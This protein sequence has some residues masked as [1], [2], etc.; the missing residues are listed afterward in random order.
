MIL[1]T[2][3]QFLNVFSSQL[4]PVFSSSLIYSLEISPVIFP[5]SPPLLSDVRPDRA[6][7]LDHCNSLR[8]CRG[9]GSPAPQG[10]HSATAA[11]RDPQAGAED[12][13]GRED[14]EDGRHAA[15][16][17]HWHQEEED[18]T[19]AG[20]EQG[21]WYTT[22]T[23]AVSVLESL[24]IVLQ[25]SHT[26]CPRDADMNQV[27][28]SCVSATSW[29]EWKHPWAFTDA[30]LCTFE[31]HCTALHAFTRQRSWH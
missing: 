17:C 1:T 12:R 21:Y 23:K 16:Y 29:V 4:S 25:I 6:G 9:A 18:H 8:M 14:E 11:N 10:G 19:G 28:W 20:T 5:F 24:F 22:D 3:S 30:H 27:L 15:V 31:L 2:L 7:E 26:L 13:H